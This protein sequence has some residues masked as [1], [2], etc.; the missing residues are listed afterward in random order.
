MDALNGVKEEVFFNCFD[1]SEKDLEQVIK[2][3]ANSKRLIF[4][5][6]D[7][8]CSKDLDFSI[9]HSFNTKY[10]CFDYCGDEDDRKTD[11]ISDPNLFENIIKAISNWGLK[12]SLE[13]I[14]INR[15]NLEISDVEEMLKK[16]GLN[17]IS[18]IEEG[19]SA[20]TD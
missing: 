16:Y 17:N 5:A 7:I 6:W 14:D 4:S 12:D 2:A 15:C 3:S 20:S 10:I 19:S 1:L 11:W 8:H 18:I 9:H 13:T